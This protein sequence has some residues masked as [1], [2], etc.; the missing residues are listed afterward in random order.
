MAKFEVEPDVAQATYAI[1]NCTVCARA[2]R[3]D[4]WH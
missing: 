4:V 2:V 1:W 3:F